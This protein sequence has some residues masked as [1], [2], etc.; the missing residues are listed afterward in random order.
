MKVDQ[1]KTI[2]AEQ[3]I[4]HGVDYAMLVKYGEAHILLNHPT[5]QKPIE[6]AIHEVKLDKDLKIT[7]YNVK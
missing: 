1:L 5:W 3:R 6:E 4:K 2:L 7:F